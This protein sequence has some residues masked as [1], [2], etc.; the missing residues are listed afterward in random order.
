MKKRYNYTLLGIM[1]VVINAIF[2][3]GMYMV[4]SPIGKI[5]SVVSSGDIFGS[6]SALSSFSADSLMNG[7]KLCA[8]GFVATIVI[9]IFLLIYYIYEER[10]MAVVMSC[11]ADVL[12]ILILFVSLSSLVNII[13]GLSFYSGLDELTSMIGSLRLVLILI[14]LGLIVHTVILLQ[15]FHVIHLSF[16]VPF[17]P[18]RFQM[19]TAA[20]LEQHDDPV[21]ATSLHED[22]QEQQDGGD[23]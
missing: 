9:A 5:A 8:F 20:Q 22:V 11:A 23:Q 13:T 4:Y 21:D 16:L 2:F 1:A 17:M 14:V 15:L 6:Y 12:E 19:V 7:A 18:N 3:I 10:K